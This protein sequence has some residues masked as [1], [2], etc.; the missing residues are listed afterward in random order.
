M[1]GGTKRMEAWETV[2]G[3]YCIREGNKRKKK[4]I[5]SN[6]DESAG[7]KSGIKLPVTS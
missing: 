6:Y 4:T 1:W 5:I 3:M 2:V 7:T